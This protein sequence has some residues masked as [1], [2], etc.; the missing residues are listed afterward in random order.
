M[1]ASAAYVTQPGATLT[2]CLT[3]LT[4]LHPTLRDT[5][6][7][8]QRQGEQDVAHG[9]AYET[10]A[11]RTARL[12]LARARF[13]LASAVRRYARAVDAAVDDLNAAKR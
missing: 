4:E 8:T 5:A 3:E 7:A 10:P 12:S 2:D 6:R 13:E 9:T 1:T 11:M